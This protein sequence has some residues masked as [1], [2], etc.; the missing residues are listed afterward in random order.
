MLV[1]SISEKNET[2]RLY[3]CVCEC[4]YTCVCMHCKYKQF[5]SL[6][7]VIELIYEPLVVTNHYEESVVGFQQQAVHPRMLELHSFSERKSAWYLHTCQ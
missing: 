1:G 7:N 2:T 4:V 3:V 6:Q 5:K